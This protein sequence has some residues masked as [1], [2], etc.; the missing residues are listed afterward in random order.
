MHNDTREAWVFL[1]VVALAVLGIVLGNLQ[2]QR[3]GDRHEEAMARAGYEKRV[4]DRGYVTWRKVCCD[5]IR[6]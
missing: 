5:S 1:G 2:C 3:E 6:P 4:E